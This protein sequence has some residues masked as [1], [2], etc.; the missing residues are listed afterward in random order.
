M[1]AALAVS[2]CILPHSVSF[3]KNFFQV[4]SNFF[5]VFRLASLA[6]Q[7]IYISTSAFICQVL[8]SGIFKFLSDSL[9]TWPPAGDLHILAYTF[10]FVKHYFSIFLTFL[11]LIFP[12]YRMQICIPFFCILQPSSQQASRSREGFQIANSQASDTTQ[13]KQQYPRS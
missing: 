3:V 1:L 7:L 6:Q 2:F 13:M 9:F 4:F 8:F 5:E 12:I 10:H 11:F